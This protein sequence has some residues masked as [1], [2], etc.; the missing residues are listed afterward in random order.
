MSE[1]EDENGVKWLAI[2]GSTHYPLDQWTKEEA[3]KDYQ[4][5]QNA[6]EDY[7]ATMRAYGA[8]ED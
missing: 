3:I 7:A 5:P 1:Y 8:Y 4:S 2:N 6:M